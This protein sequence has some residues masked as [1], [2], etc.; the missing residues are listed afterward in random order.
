M[1]LKNFTL[2]FKID[3]IYEGFA[4]SE[5]LLSFDKD[6]LKIEFST[7]DSFIGIIKSDLKLVH[8]PL[9][10]IA[11]IKY[12]KGFFGDKLII[13]TNSLDVAQKLPGSEGNEIELNIK[14]K[15][16]DDANMFASKLN[17]LIAENRLDE[18]EHE[19]F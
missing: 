15:N 12:D 13:V 3:D 16:R 11:N 18:I 1:Y 17:L 6:S 10:K 5:G 9:N 7:K 4:E 2:P 8:I 19:S 14:K